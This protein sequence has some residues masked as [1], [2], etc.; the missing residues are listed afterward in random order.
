VSF[1]PRTI[2]ALTL[3]V[4]PREYDS[5]NADYFSCLL[6]SASGQTMIE[7]RKYGRETKESKK[8]RVLKTPKKYVYI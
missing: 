1:Q 3:A 5:K 2:S 7:K 8:G 6:H 4:P